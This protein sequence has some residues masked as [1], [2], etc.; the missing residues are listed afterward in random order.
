MKPYRLINPIEV[1]ELNQRISQII[2]DWSETYCV[3]PLGMTLE[4]PH[5]D[6]SPSTI[7]AFAPDLACID[8][9]Y[10]NTL[11]TALFGH[12]SLSF[13]TASQE[14]VQILFNNL[15]QTEQSTLQSQ[16]TEMPSWFYA[17]SPCLLLTL[18]CNEH[19]FTLILNPEWVYQQLSKNTSSKNEL[20][21]LDEALAEHTVCLNL[22]L[23]PSPL[24]VTDVA[25]IQVGDIL[26]TNHPITAPLQLKRGTE[27]FAHAE[28]GQSQQHKSII[29]KRSS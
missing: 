21:S 19:Q 3:T 8:G 12:E 17:G 26:S 14:L 4:I 20:S 15:F 1:R 13:S 24:S 23:T 2:L 29:L 22:E 16:S 9:D 25:G 28:L 6:Y 18:N 10:L 7:Q 5:K 11:N 27:L